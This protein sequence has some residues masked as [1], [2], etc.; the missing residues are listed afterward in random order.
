MGTLA[1]LTPFVAAAIALSRTSRFFGLTVFFVYL[2]VEGLVKLIG[3]YHP[4]VH[5]GVDIV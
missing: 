5:I 1:L 2:S 4:I 3:N